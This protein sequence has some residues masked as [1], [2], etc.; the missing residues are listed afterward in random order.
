[1]RQTGS[2]AAWLFAAALL[3]GCSGFSDS[4]TGHARP[5]AQS[6]GYT[7]VAEELAQLLA[8]SSIPDSSLTPHWAGQL[9]RLWADYVALAALYT[10][11]DTTERLDFERFL[12]D[13]RHIAA[14]AV[15]QY[16]DSVVL[17]GIE[18]DEDELR[19]YFE[20]RQP[21]TRLDVRRIVL[22]VPEDADRALRDSLNRVAREI[23]T[24]IVGG[25][26]FM[27]TAR[28]VSEEPLEARGQLLSYQGHE[29]F[30]PTVDSLLFQLEPGAISP[31]I[32]TPEAILIYSVERR[33]APDFERSRD[34]VLQQMIEERRQERMEV[35]LDSLLEKAR[36][37]IPEGAVEVAR[38]VAS[39]DPSSD[40]R[41][42]GALRLALWEGGEFTVGELR[43]LFRVRGDIRERF[44]RGNDED[45]DYYLMQLARDEILSTAAFGAGQAP[46]EEQRA[47]MAR[48][49][50]EQLAG[51][52][53]QMKISR[54][55]VSDPAYDTKRES[56]A[57]MER[58]LAEAA[59][60]RWL[61]PFRVVLDQDYD[62]RVHESGTET[63]ARQ[64]RELRSARV[65]LEQSDR[66]S[67]PAP[68]STETHEE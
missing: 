12:E 26:D 51:I 49:A 59:P 4:L 36:R 47:E 62:I 7:L 33:R 43:R 58:V 18:P 45:I 27:E 1:M 53:R 6:A 19:S 52:A 34:L 23:R 11:P 2:G 66:D 56:I 37:V 57:F 16:R 22:K 29:D 65:A 32:E 28:G 9:A 60:L 54:A 24:Q 63:A 31:P 15:L 20:E 5:V 68:D 61:G 40:G 3:S 42:S 41:I 48:T 44:R 13:Q 55:L 21:L 17:S 64:A 30:A 46:T 39:E 38:G 35:A 25:A 67:V 14:T 8:G 50:A 10:E